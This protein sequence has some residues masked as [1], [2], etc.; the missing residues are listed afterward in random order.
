MKYSPDYFKY[1][2]SQV[3]RR[4]Q[5]IEETLS[6]ISEDAFSRADYE[7]IEKLNNLA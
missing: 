5:D 7:E 4:A 1:T 6:R 3:E 2:L